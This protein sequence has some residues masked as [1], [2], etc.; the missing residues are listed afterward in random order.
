M[1]EILKRLCQPRAEKQSAYQGTKR[2]NSALIFKKKTAGERAEDDISRLT[3][4]AITEPINH[5][6]NG[7]PVFFG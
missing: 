3:S 6:F 7:D 4:P 2:I 5:L 1:D